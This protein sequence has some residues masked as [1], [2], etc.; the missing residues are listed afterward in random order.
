MNW[1][2][3][4]RNQ[5][6]FSFNWIEFLIPWTI[7]LVH[8]VFATEK[9]N[10]PAIAVQICSII[11]RYT[12]QLTTIAT[13][14]DMRTRWP[15]SSTDSKIRIECIVSG[16]RVH[17]IPGEPA[18]QVLLTAIRMGFFA[19]T[20]TVC[21]IWFWIWCGW[22]MWLRWFCMGMV[23][24]GRMWWMVSGI[25]RWG[26]RRMW[27]MVTGIGRW[28]FRRVCVVRVVPWIG[29]CW[30]CGCW[31]CG[32]RP[33]VGCRGWSCWATFCGLKIRERRYAMIKF[34]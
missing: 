12:E 15:I 1:R 13:G 11:I 14:W 28:G 21:C 33:R 10:F 17:L 25:G 9:F 8:L 3:S 16:A 31:L 7:A 27:W 18:E 32:W 26:F 2:C 30:L 20:I 4:C 23:W 6:A 34:G 22:L 24:F 5:S 19:I 29:C